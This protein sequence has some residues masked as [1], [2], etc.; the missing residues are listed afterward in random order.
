MVLQ[1]IEFVWPFRQVEPWERGIIIVCGR[2]VFEVGPGVY[3]LFWY[4]MKMHTV[5]MLPETQHL[6]TVEV[7][8]TENGETISYGVLIETQ[9]LD[10]KLAYLTVEDYDNKSRR[11]AWGIIAMQLAD[12]PSKRLQA[13]DQRA[14]RRTMIL[15][16][17]KVIERYGVTCLTLAFPTF[18]GGMRSYRLFTG[19]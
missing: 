4:F 17:N 12:L 6:G 14:L 8:T 11:D 3:P 19:S 7:V 1:F 10:A 2:W 5:N 13:G 9:V 15:S 16:I 18:V